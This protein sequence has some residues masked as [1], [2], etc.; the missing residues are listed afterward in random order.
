M[1]RQ[2]SWCFI[3]SDLKMCQSTT[4]FSTFDREI[5]YSRNHKAKHDNCNYKQDI[6]NHLSLKWVNGVSY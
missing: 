2:T 4:A 6:H 1:I 5:F 3:S